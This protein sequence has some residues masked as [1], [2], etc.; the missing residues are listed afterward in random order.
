MSKQRDWTVVLTDEE[1]ERAARLAARSAR[2]AAR[3]QFGRLSGG[4]DRGLAQWLAERKAWALRIN[5]QTAQIA[6]IYAHTLDPYGIEPELPAEL[7]QVGREYFARD[8]HCD[9]WVSFH[10]LPDGVREALW[11]RIEDDQKRNGS[12]RG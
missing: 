8:P 11:N 1:L 3:V 7:Q 5:P 9:V 10:D 2:V 6:W 4:D 12:K